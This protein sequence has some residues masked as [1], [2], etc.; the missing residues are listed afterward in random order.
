[1]SNKNRF[2]WRSQRKIKK[3][4]SSFFFFG[5]LKIW[6]LFFTFGFSLPWMLL[7]VSKKKPAY[8]QEHGVLSE[9]Y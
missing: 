3:Q 9:E 5:L 6:I 1:V 8:N 2:L 4:T 7:Q